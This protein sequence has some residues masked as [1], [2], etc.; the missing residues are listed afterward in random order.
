MPDPRR[1]IVRYL[2]V[3]DGGARG[4]FAPFARS[5]MRDALGAMRSGTG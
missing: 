2:F 3:L 4:L 1:V 5:A